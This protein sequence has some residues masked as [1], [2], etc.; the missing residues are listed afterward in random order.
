MYV[1]VNMP[2]DLVAAMQLEGRDPATAVLEATALEAFR[3]KK[4][5]SYQLRLILGIESRYELD[6]FLKEREI[7]TYTVEDFEQDMA[8]MALLRNR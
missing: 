8:T 3:E 5:T 7:E 4:I 6:G 1:T 2:D